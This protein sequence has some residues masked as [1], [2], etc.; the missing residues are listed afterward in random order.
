MGIGSRKSRVHKFN[1]YNLPSLGQGSRRNCIGLK[2][3][4]EAEMREQERE[5]SPSHTG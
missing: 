2:Y 5:G 1:E 3:L 4:E